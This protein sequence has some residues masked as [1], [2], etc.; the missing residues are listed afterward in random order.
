[1]LSSLCCFIPLSLT[2]IQMNFYT[3]ILS[4]SHTLVLI[5]FL[6]LFKLF[7]LSDIPIPF[8]MFKILQKWELISEAFLIILTCEFSFTALNSRN[9]LIGVYT[10]LCTFRILALSCIWCVTLRKL[11]NLLCVSDLH[12]KW[13]T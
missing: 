4:D 8:H 7:L 12:V 13:A 10:L 1:M 2:N 11:F 6:S 3:S 9:L 5:T